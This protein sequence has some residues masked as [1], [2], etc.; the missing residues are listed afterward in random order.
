MSFDSLLLHS[1]VIAHASTSGR[2]ADGQAL[3]ETGSA[4]TP[5]R[6]EE[7][8]GSWPAGPGADPLIADARIYLP[9]GPV[10]SELDTITRIDVDP[11]QAYQVLAVNDAAGQGHH[12]EILARRIPL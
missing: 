11:A 10:V 1:L 4:P 3:T 9:F 8:G 7:S 6:V 2:D 5:G 12:L